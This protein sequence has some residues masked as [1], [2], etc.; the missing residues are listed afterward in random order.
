MADNRYPHAWHTGEIQRACYARANWRCEHCGCEFVPGTTKAIE[1]R[2]KDGKPR[3]L[4]VHHLDG[5][6]ANCD[7]RN[8]LTCCQVCHLHIQAVWKPGGIIPATW[9]PVP[10][11]ITRRG[12]P[13][14]V[15]G[16]QLEL[17]A[18]VRDGSR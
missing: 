12:L 7:W 11:W 5:N 2:N 10:T 15:A 17:F 4:T 16:V 14:L 18:E 13:F 1:A 3:I 9:N 6:P 8:L